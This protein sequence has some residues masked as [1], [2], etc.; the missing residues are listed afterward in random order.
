MLQINGLSDRVKIRRTLYS[1]W[2]LVCLLLAGQ[3]SL[4]VHEADHTSLTAS[5]PCVV[6]LNHSVFE[7][8]APA[9]VLVI[10]V[11]ITAEPLIAFVSTRIAKPYLLSHSEPRA[12]PRYS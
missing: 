10:K 7:G 12:P 3:F 9:P 8:A 4:L 5:T 2:L 11:E 1:G 6:C